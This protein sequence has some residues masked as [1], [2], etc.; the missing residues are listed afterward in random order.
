M[1]MFIIMIIAL[2]VSLAHASSPNDS[3]ELSDGDKA[4]FVEIRSA[5]MSKEPER[6]ARLVLFPIKLIIDH[7][8]VRFAS[9]QKFIKR[10]DEIVTADLIR[11]IKE[12]DV[13]ELAKSWRGICVGRGVLWFEEVRR[14]EEIVFYYKITGIR[15][16]AVRDPQPN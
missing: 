12:Q 10:Y 1:K 3:L 9:E 2:G 4:F 11:V 15:P 8:T 7:K 5:I 6:L 13:N 14:K 16:V